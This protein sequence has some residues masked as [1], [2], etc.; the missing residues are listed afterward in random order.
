MKITVKQLTQTAVLL[1]LC[2]AFQTLKSI[3]VYITGPLVNAILILATW[4][5]GLP[6]G[7]A[8]ALLSPVAAFFLGA[9]PV[10]NLIPVMMPVVMVGNSILVL[11]VNG[12]KERQ[13]PGLLLGSVC[14]AGFLWLTVWYAVLPLFAGNIPEAKR[15]AM[16]AMVRVQFSLT[17]LITALLGSLIAWLVWQRVRPVFRK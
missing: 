16:T 4:A 2:I 14:K 15:S 7:L 6:G 3:S 12:F 1:A 9:T 5:V 13:I 10:M 11:F 8:I 17:Q